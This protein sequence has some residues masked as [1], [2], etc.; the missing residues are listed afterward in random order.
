MRAS[1]LFVLAAALLPIPALAQTPPQRQE[2]PSQRETAPPGGSG[3]PT[4]N[5]II[6][7]PVAPRVPRGVIEPPMQVDPGIQTTVP[8]P[9]PGTTP[10]IPPPG[11]PGGDP[12]IVPR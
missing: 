7:G 9:R 3:G 10:V 4:G 1:W 2:P 5:D 6:E 8:E 11:A 12:T